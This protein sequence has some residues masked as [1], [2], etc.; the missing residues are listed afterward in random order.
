MKHRN[1]HHMKPSSR[2]GSSLESNLLTIDIDKHNL[3]HKIFGNLT[4]T[5]IIV[6]M[7]KTAKIKH[8]E[9]NE[10]KISQFYK[11]VK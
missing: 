2:S 4:W 9:Y 3:L 7:I 1:K 5:E 6:I 11:F 8:Y 10:P